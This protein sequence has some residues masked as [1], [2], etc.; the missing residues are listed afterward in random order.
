MVNRGNRNPTA[1]GDARL[2]EEA[3][4]RRLRCFPPAGLGALPGAAILRR[5]KIREP[6]ERNL[7]NFHATE[8]R[9]CVLLLRGPETPG[10]NLRTRAE[11][12]YAFEDGDSPCAFE[13][14]SLMRREGR[15]WR[16]F[17]APAGPQRVAFNALVSVTNRD[18]RTCDS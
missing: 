18:R 9:A 1:I 14:T 7:Y 13:L 15:L 8:I 4:R 11:R 16:K 2:G 3:V 10:Q 17:S 12:M 6:A 5:R